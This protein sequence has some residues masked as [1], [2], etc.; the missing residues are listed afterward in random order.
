MALTLAEQRELDELEYE[1]LLNESNRRAPI[2]EPSSAADQR[3]AADKKIMKSVMDVAGPVIDYAG[4]IG[5]YAATG[6]AN[7]P[8]ALATGKSL[9]TP[10]DAAAVLKG[11][12]P[13]MSEYMTRAGVPEGDVVNYPFIGPLSTRDIGGFAL[14]IAT[15]PLMWTQGLTKGLKEFTANKGKDIYKSGLKNLDI[16]AAKYGKEPVSDLLM[17]EGVTGSYEQIQKQMDELSKKYLT[18]R[19]A[20]LKKATMAGAEVDMAEAMAPLLNKIN[21]LKRLNDPNTNRLAKI[22]EKDAMTYISRGAKEPAQIIRELPVGGEYAPEYTKLDTIRGEGGKVSY[23]RTPDQY[24][25]I[26]SLPTGEDYFPS[27]RAVKSETGQL[28]IGQIQ[29][30]GTIPANVEMG[31]IIPEST[32]FN[33]KVVD[34][35]VNPGRI[36]GEYVPENFALREPQK[37]LDLTERIR[38]PSPIQASAWKSSTYNKVGSPAYETAK[39]TPLGKELNKTKAFGLKTATESSVKKALGK[40]A[41]D[42]LSELNK[43]LSQ[44]LTTDEK[45]A[46]EAAKEIRKNTVTSVDAPLA[47]LNPKAAVAKK[48]ADVAKMTKFRT[49]LGKALVDRSTSPMILERN[50]LLSPWLELNRQREK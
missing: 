6:L 33:P 29:P 37:V 18:E 8:Y 19:D 22:M 21:D 16:E 1:Q 44:I 47:M 40:N 25:E 42:D 50:L 46:Q 20:I 15:D 3:L 26:Q 14:D 36:T 45:A 5:R 13:I 38:G 41:A 39:R 30:P 17:K 12:A 28:P 32:K 2:E 48:I 43:K 24:S 31:Q 49:E 27:Y 4:G 9:T 7:I 35:E 34:L 11:H 10:E 23:K